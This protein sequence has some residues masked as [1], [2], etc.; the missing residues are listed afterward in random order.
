[1]TSN[2]I[3]TSMTKSELEEIITS[4]FRKL[5]SSNPVVEGSQDK[6]MNQKE[7]AEFLGVSQSTLITWKKRGLVPYEQLQ[8]SSKIRFY[9]S[10]LKLVLLKNSDLLQPARK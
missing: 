1:M 4:T 9:K 10:Q 3:L 6:I 7:A 8:G 2:I 5:V